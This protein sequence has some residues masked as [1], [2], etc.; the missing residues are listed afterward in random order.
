MRDYFVYTTTTDPRASVMLA[1]LTQEYDARYGNLFSPGGAA[2]EMRRYPPETFAPPHGNFLLLLRQGQAIAGGAF[3]RLDEHTAE[4]KRIWTHSQFR[5]QGLAGLVL[6]ELEAQC[7]RQGYRQI[8]LTTGCRQPEA[9][10]LYLRHGYQAQFDP[11]GDLEAL[12]TLP[13]T[14]AVPRQASAQS[15]PAHWTE[16]AGIAV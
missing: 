14:K 15:H 6:Q 10:G 16:L 7:Q 3:K 2:E 1:E 13:F 11:Q 4:F 12:R 8:Y 5:R 9:V